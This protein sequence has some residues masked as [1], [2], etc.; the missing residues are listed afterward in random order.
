MRHGSRVA[1][2]H[3]VIVAFVASALL[4]LATAAS[5]TAAVPDPGDLDPD[6]ANA[7]TATLNVQRNDYA[8]GVGR[9]IAV[10]ASL[11]RSTSEF[12][13]ARYEPNGG[14]GTPRSGSGSSRGTSPQRLEVDR[15]AGVK[16]VEPR[17]LLQKRVRH[18]SIRGE[19]QHRLV[20]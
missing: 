18:R 12:A 20:S 16:T 9:L 14:S 5:A 11:G 15:P 13:L 3:R 2:P 1:R 17:D 8:A 10:G 4:G 19:R 7:G 6:F